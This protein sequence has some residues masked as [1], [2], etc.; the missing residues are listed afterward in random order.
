MYTFTDFYN[1]LLIGSKML[2]YNERYKFEYQ[3]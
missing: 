1:G 3:I 2:S